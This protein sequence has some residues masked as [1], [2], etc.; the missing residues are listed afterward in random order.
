MGIHNIKEKAEDAAK[1]EE[2][3]PREHLQPEDREQ[4]YREKNNDKK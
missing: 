1:T 2:E 4:I 3:A